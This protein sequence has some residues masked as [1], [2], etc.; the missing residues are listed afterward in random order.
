MFSFIIPSRNNFQRVNSVL[1][2]PV[3]SK[4][5]CIL[6]DDFSDSPH[7]YIESPLTKI[8]YNKSKQCLSKSWNQG[9]NESQYDDLIILSDRYNLRQEEFDTLLH[10][11]QKPYPL[12]LIA[13]FHFCYINKNLIEKIGG[14]EEGFSAGGYEDTDFLNRCATNNIG[15]H[16]HSHNGGM[17]V[18]KSGWGGKNQDYRLNQIFYDKKWKK[19]TNTHLPKQI[20]ND[21]YEISFKFPIKEKTGSMIEF[22]DSI[23]PSN[24]SFSSILW[25]ANLNKK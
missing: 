17:T 2:N 18:G 12:I 25:E 14:F 6:I 1:R 7:E 8:I 16:I 13:G 4:N 9:I 20:L 23:I 11:K 3:I 21:S 5:E 24:S 10:F 22:K 15:I 19:K